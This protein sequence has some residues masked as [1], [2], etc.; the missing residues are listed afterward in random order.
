MTSKIGFFKSNLQ[1][2]FPRGARRAARAIVE[3]IDATSQYDQTLICL[4][5]KKIPN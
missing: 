3:I 1:D 2:T 5:E 4:D